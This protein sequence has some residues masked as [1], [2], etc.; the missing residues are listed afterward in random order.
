MEDNGLA[1]GEHG[2]DVGHG[3]VLPRRAVLVVPLLVVDGRG[4][5]VLALGAA[6]CQALRSGLLPRED[7]AS[8]L[9]GP[10]RSKKGLLGRHRPFRAVRHFR[11]KWATCTPST[12]QRG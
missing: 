3:G 7:H 4:L 6:L 11:R 1:R 8:N 10:V 9:V 2:L 5:E 12:L